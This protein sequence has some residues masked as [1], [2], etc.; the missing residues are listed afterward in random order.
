LLSPERSFHPSSIGARA[1][2]NRGGLPPLCPQESLRGH[3]TATGPA[4]VSFFST[5]TYGDSRDPV[6][7]LARR[8]QSADG[9]SL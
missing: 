3:A 5:V 1:R 2:G 9:N 6:L 8:L 4:F 7:G